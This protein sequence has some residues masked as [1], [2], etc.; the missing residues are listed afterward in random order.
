MVPE[1]S[2]GTGLLTWMEEPIRFS[3]QV[4]EEKWLVLGSFLYI[5]L[6]PLEK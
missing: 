1:I 6:R 3:I 4:V 2:I 5:P